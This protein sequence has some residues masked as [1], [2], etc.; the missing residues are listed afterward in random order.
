MSKSKEKKPPVQS[1]PQYQEDTALKPM[2]ILL[3]PLILVL[4]Y[5]YMN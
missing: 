3:I 5:G 1:Q 2:L 4:V